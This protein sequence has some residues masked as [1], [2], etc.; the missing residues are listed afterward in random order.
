MIDHSVRQQ[1]IDELNRETSNE[2]YDRLVEK[3]VG[4]VEVKREI[5]NPTYRK[6]IEDLNASLE[7]E[8]NELI[9]TMNVWKREHNKTL[10]ELQSKWQNA[11]DDLLSIADEF[12]R[13][14]AHR[15]WCG[16]KGPN[17]EHINCGL[18]TA[19]RNARRG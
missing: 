10:N 4:N 17:M 12:E 19:I 15:C 5:D 3:I 8:K 1:S 13:M 2:K 11:R 9:R 7:Q 6:G 14:T 18:A 16:K